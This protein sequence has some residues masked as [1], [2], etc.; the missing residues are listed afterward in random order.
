M[1][2]AKSDWKQPGTSDHD[3]PLNARGRRVA[4]LMA[5]HLIQQSVTVDIIVASTAERVRE[6]VELMQDHWAEQV[7]V[8]RNSSLYL[9][10]PQQILSEIQTLHDSWESALVVAHNP[11]MVS[12]VSHLADLD[13]AMPTAAV[14]IFEADIASWTNKLSPGNCRLKALWKPRELEA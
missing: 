2:H 5:H 13:V 14:A 11:G 6:T 4:V 1:R 3:R 7:Q 12:L 8:L 10:A 9:A